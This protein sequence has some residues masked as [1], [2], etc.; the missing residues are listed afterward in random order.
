[1][2]ED[3]K[4]VVGFMI[5][6]LLL[7]FVLNDIPHAILSNI[8]LEL[9]T[10]RK[11]VKEETEWGKETYGDK[12][13]AKES[14]GKTS[15]GNITLFHGTDKYL[16]NDIL[17][18]GIEPSYKGW[19]LEKEE[20]EEIPEKERPNPAVWLAYTPYLAFFFGNVAIQVTIP[21]SWVTEANDGVLVERH[22]PPT[23]ID[24]YVFIEDWK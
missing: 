6:A 24:R 11:G 7:K 3:V 4:A 18:K 23:M 8:T 1:V 10:V 17:K 16:L 12:S 19:S 9:T 15:N 5:S 14:W 2:Y 21:L 22:I 13:W 20:A